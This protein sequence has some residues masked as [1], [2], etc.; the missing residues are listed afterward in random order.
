MNLF[1]I[2]RV[3]LALVYFVEFMVTFNINSR[4]SHLQLKN[5]FTFLNTVS[6]ERILEKQDIYFYNSL[7]K[8]KD[9]FQ[10]LVENNVKFYRYRN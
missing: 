4:I 5:R 2:A 10:S 3:F 8:Q 1:R 6:R 9:K 7:T